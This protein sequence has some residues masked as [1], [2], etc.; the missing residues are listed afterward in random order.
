MKKIKEEYKINFM[1]LNWLQVIDKIYNR[2]LFRIGQV[3]LTTVK[4]ILRDHTL[5]M[6]EWGPEGFCGGQEIF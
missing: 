3:I 4:L 6:K 1:M 2:L 5:S